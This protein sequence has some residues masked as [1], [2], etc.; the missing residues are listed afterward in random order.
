MYG[1][2]KGN[3]YIYIYREER[4]RAN[5]NLSNAL[6]GPERLFRGLI[7]GPNSSFGARRGN[8]REHE[9]NKV[10]RCIEM[11]GDV[12]TCKRKFI[13]REREQIRTCQMLFRGPNASFGARFGARTRLSG[14]ERAQQENI[15]KQG[16]AMYRDVMRCQ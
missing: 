3:I 9:K 11:Y 16:K 13:E 2:V 8:A 15:R 14:P 7:R 6:S 10:K 1:H 5:P 4:E 12:R